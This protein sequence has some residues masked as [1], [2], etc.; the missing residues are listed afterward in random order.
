[1]STKLDGSS[2]GESHSIESDPAGLVNVK[3]NLDWLQS[4]N[5]ELISSPA[6]ASD[7]TLFE[8][9]LYQADMIIF[10]TDALRPFTS[11]REVEF[12]ERFV[13][14]KKANVLLAVNNVDHLENEAAEKPV[15]FSKIQEYLKELQTTEEK[16]EPAPA[17]DT[18]SSSTKSADVPEVFMVSA[19][20]ARKAQ[21]LPSAASMG[22]DFAKIWSA[23]GVQDIKT[24]ILSRASSTDR[25]I[26]QF[27]SASFVASQAVRRLYADQEASL[28]LLNS[29]K[30][31][32]ENILV[33]GIVAGEERLHHDFEKKDLAIIPDHLATLTDAIRTYFASISGIVRLMF[34]A[35]SISEDVKAKM[36]GHTLLKAEYQVGHSSKLVD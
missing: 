23:S 10:V 35:E 6:T 27:A 1:M 32:V 30:K 14:H 4:Y 36:R 9:S 8:D 7:L 26:H 17:N 19:R 20:R 5:V 33:P 2:F 15:V 25:G 22:S 34:K 13:Q 12:L 24:A 16:A 31:R 29:V 18:V 28:S 3:L 11:A 21:S